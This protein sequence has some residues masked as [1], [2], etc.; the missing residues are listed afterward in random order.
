MSGVQQAAR[1]AKAQQV[2]AALT[3]F[4]GERVWD[5]ANHTD[6]V[7]GALVATILSQ[8]TSDLN[9]GRAYAA[10]RAAFPGGW[11]DVRQAPVSRVADAI[12]AGGLANV[13]APRIQAILQDI[14]ERTGQTSLDYLTVWE[15]EAILDHLRALPGV[16]PKT[17][18]CVLM[19]NLGRPVLPVDTH[20]HRVSQRL[21]LIGPKVSADQAHEDLL[22]LIDPS[23]VYSF[24]VHLIE[25]GRRICHARKPE[26][27]RC[28]VQVECDYYQR[29]V[30]TKT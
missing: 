27:A 28:P 26:C 21:G 13:K 7:L 11:D 25:H 20:V 6:D 14:Y 15:D 16:G 8:N 23:Q 1:R 22:T 24:H 10:L 17:A 12:R 4:Y 3:R 29:E 18:A 30:W 5:K 19:F 2:E 9:S